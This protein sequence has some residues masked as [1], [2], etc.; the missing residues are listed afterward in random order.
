MVCGS[1]DI[2]EFSLT[3]TLLDQDKKKYFKIQPSSAGPASS[4]YSSQ[5]V[6]R[7]KLRDEKEAKAARDHAR[8]KLRIQQ[9][10]LLT[11]PLIGGALQREYG[12]DG[13]EP[14]KIL[15]GGLVR[16]GHVL[17]D[18]VRVAG[19]SGMFTIIYRPDIGPSVI[20]FRLGKIPFTSHPSMKL[21]VT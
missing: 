3:H 19:G 13:L 5:D 15:A 18:E 6:K 10:K 1:L 11:E 9:S 12:N 20:D 2:P 21:W 17:I 7:R 14:A 4:V 16:Q 8:E